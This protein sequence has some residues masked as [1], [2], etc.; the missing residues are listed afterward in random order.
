MENKKGETS[1]DSLT[2]KIMNIHASTISRLSLRRER[3]TATNPVF[4]IDVVC[5]P[6]RR[7]GS[8][9]R[10]KRGAAT[11]AA[12]VGISSRAQL[13]PR[14]SSLLPRE[15]R[16]VNEAERFRAV[17]KQLAVLLAVLIVLK[18]QVN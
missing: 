14:P 16:S 1:G 13:Q 9:G 10:T 11:P 15:D 4:S 7:C 5:G 2:D 6:I 3:P 12:Y 8:E 17:P 18:T